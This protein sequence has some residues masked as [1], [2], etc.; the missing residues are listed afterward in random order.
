MGYDICG[1]ASQFHVYYWFQMAFLSSLGN[2]EFCEVTMTALLFGLLAGLCCVT[3]LDWC[4]GTSLVALHHHITHRLQQSAPRG[5][6]ANP[7]HISPTIVDSQHH[8]CSI[9][10]YTELYSH[11]FIV[12]KTSNIYLHFRGLNPQLSSSDI[13]SLISL[14]MIPIQILFYFFNFLGKLL[15]VATSQLENSVFC[16]SLLPFIPCWEKYRICHENERK[17]SMPWR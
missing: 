17:F 11:Q 3:A 9:V 15:V 2:V 12:S 1:Q 6:T 13:E 5:D 16:I 10:L 4:D 14:E 7:T 8:Y